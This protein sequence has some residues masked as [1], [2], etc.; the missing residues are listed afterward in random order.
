M[1]FYEYR[2][3]SCGHE[4][5]ALQKIADAP[6]VYCPECGEARLKKLVSKSAFRLKGG[7][8]YATDF[9]HSGARPGK[10]GASKDDAKDGDSARAG[11]KGGDGGG[12]G[13]SGGSGG[14]GKS[15][16]GGGDGRGGKTGGDGSSNGGGG[17]TAGQSTA[18]EKL[19][20]SA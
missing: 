12:D 5:E 4:L 15:G 14:D 20:K 19:Q 11:G 10:D 1:P 9:K 16:D 3:E 7:G 13:K 6:L 17:K 8:W 18:A 2:C